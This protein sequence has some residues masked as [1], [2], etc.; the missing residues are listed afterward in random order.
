MAEAVGTPNREFTRDI[1]ALSAVFGFLDQSMAGTAVD[2]R[3]R[4]ILQLVVEELFTNMVKYN[5]AGGG[6][7]RVRVTA[8][9]DAITIELVDPD[10]EPFNPLDHPA[11]NTAAPIQQRRR[12]GLGIHL[13]KTMADDIGYRY[14]GREMTVSVT[15]RLE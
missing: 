15:K 13:V 6:G 3:S 7:I 2:D 12:G 4:M 1:G 11:V 5:P 10:A 14:E 9:D 8:G